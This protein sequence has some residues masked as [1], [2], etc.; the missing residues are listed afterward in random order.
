VI[1][2]RTVVKA[3]LIVVCVLLPGIAGAQGYGTI[4]GRVTDPTGAAVVSATVV[5]TEVGTSQTRTITSGQDGFYTLTSLRPSTYDLTVDGSGFKKFVQK[6]ITLQATESLT[7]DIALTIGAATES[8][9]V[10]A[11]SVQVDT[12]TP[13]LKE[14]VDSTRM[15]EIPLNATRAVGGR[16]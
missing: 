14:V 12:T 13:T 10:Y 8:V 3:L 9:S 2:R 7:V 11:D 6:S 16:T 1:N 4:T 15:A 5:A